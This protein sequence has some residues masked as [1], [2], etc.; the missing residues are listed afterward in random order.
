[1]TANVV[2]DWRDEK[3]RDW[4]FLILRFAITRDARD[5][6]AVLT[7]AAELDALGTRRCWVPRF[8]MRTGTEVCAAI[9]GIDSP[10]RRSILLTHARRVDDPRLKRAFLAAVDLG[11]KSKMSDSAV[12]GKMSQRARLWRGL[13]GA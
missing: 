7:L 8:F 9:L 12:G 2:G 3:V 5:R 11:K 1:M 10:N 6:A 13:R 4:L